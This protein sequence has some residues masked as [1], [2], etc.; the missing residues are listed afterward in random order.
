MV[1]KRLNEKSQDVNYIIGIILVIVEPHQ[2][3]EC[4]I[5]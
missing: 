5:F 3:E 4:C 1:L 2:E